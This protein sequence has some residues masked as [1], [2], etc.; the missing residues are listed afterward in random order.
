[1]QKNIH[2]ILDKNVSPERAFFAN[3]LNLDSD[4][5]HIDP[6]QTAIRQVK[7]FSSGAISRVDKVERRSLSL[8]ETKTYAEKNF[9]IDTRDTLLE[10]DKEKRPLANVI[11]RSTWIENLQK[12]LGYERSYVVPYSAHVSK[13]ADGVYKLQMQ[14]PW[15]SGRTYCELAEEKA[16][17]IS[18][19]GM[20]R[21]E[22][23]KTWKNW[24]HVQRR[25][26][27]GEFL[28]KSIQVDILMYLAGKSDHHAMNTMFQLDD[29]GMPSVIAIDNGK[30]FDVNVRGW[31]RYL[32]R[33]EKDPQ[34]DLQTELAKAGFE[35]ELCPNYDYFVC[36]PP[37]G[38]HA[39]E[40]MDRLAHAV[41]VTRMFTPYT[42]DQKSARQVLK[43]Y[44]MYKKTEG[45]D[46]LRAM[47]NGISDEEFMAFGDRLTSLGELISMSGLDVCYTRKEFDNE[48]VQNDIIMGARDCD[49]RCMSPLVSAINY[50]VSLRRRN[51]MQA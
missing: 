51:E 11:Q 45:Q 50:I 3:L 39:P 47:F 46:Q 29:G 43:L 22:F 12:L 21:I 26:F 32:V 27:I 16:S 23:E 20:T 5:V 13:E 33:H 9:L 1:M 42:I 48:A 7:C 37:E 41:G 36:I 44:S 2:T 15:I 30:A 35:I 24:S 6:C 34:A 14:S 17:D 49:E 4:N 8:G 38:L 40:L 18:L 28:Y 25:K 10:I 19:G 31:S